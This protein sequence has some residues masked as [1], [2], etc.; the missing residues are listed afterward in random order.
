M[1]IVL[2]R[3]V[4]LYIVIVFCMRL[5]GKKQIGQ[6]QP[7]ELVVTILLSNIATLPIEDINIP[8]LMGL[9]PIVAI[10][11]LDVFFSYLSLSSK[12]F[13]RMICGSP[14]III[15]NG[16]LDQKLL[17]QLRFTV[18]DLF[19][20]LR[21]QQVFDISQV[22]LAI[23]ETT[24]QISVYV[25]RSEGSVTPTDMNISVNDADPPQLIVDDGEV[26]ENSLSLCGVDRKW[27]EKTLKKES[28][29]L[30]EVFIMTCD[31][32]EKYNIIRKE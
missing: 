17:K 5:M 14:K 26:L 15:A 1:L 22:Q 9:V 4:I 3:A 13:R 6:L 19:E 28:C 32:N 2:F 25:K 20:S 24:G 23:V 21:A 29:T 8:V 31:G 27:L 11:S 30:E 16:R 18:D 12:S 10:V 7:S